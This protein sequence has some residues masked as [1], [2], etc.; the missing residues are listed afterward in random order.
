M[1]FYPEL[2]L[3]STRS[4]AAGMPADVAVCPELLPSARSCV[5][6]M[7]IDDAVYSEL[8]PSA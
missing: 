7:L 3:P 6:G 4:F 8:L 5:A 1:P 2:L